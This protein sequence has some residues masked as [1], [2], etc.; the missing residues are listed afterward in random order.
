MSKVTYDRAS[1][2][3]DKPLVWL[4]GQVKTPP[5]SRDARIEAGVLLRR[6]QRGEGLALPHSRPMPSIGRG[7]HELRIPDANRS[8]RIAYHVDADAIVILDVFSKSTRRTPRTVI[9]QCKARLRSFDEAAGG[10]TR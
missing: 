4:H 7:C 3:S 6:L 9:E 5:F 1:L 8:W 10:R 2:K